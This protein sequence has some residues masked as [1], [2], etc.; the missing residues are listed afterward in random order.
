MWIAENLVFEIVTMALSRGKRNLIVVLL[1]VGFLSLSA[2]LVVLFQSKMPALICFI[3]FVFIVMII[4]NKTLQLKRLGSIDMLKD[5]ILLVNEVRNLK[6][7][8]P[9]SDVSKI[10]IRGGAEMDLQGRHAIKKRKTLFLD[11]TLKT[12]EEVIVHIH[13][14]EDDELTADQI[15]QYCKTLNITCDRKL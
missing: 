12:K 13:V 1:F 9:T 11:L 3:P 4:S 10:F 14:P 5:E 6:R 8:I 7:T 15:H 2:L